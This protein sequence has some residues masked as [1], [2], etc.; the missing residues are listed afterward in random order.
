MF[1]GRSKSIKSCNRLLSTFLAIV[2]ASFSSIF[3]LNFSAQFLQVY[4]AL[5]F[6]GTNFRVVRAELKGQGKV[7][8]A[9]YKRSLMSASSTSNLPR[10]LMD[11]SATASQM[12][13]FFSETCKEFMIKMNDLKPDSTEVQEH[14]AGFTF[15]FPCNLKSIK[16]AILMEWT[17]GFETGYI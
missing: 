1:N 11:S 8:F 13:D 17:K 7:S 9:Q 15:S 12:F 10:G 5:D 14:K 2:L 3:F 16:S 4:Y 6:G